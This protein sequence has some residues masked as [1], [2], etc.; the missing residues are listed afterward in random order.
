MF[1]LDGQVRE[2]PPYR[3]VLLLLHVQLP[4]KL[5]QILEKKPMIHLFVVEHIPSHMV[6]IIPLTTLLTIALWIHTNNK[7]GVPQPFIGSSSVNPVS[8]KWKLVRM[9]STDFL[10]FYNTKRW[11]HPQNKWWN[12]DIFW[13]VICFVRTVFFILL[14]IK[15]VRVKDK[16]CIWGHSVKHFHRVR[17]QPEPVYGKLYNI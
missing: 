1:W 9:W 14:W 6:L 8:V 11:S 13:F 4:L 17:E 15:K 10:S 2:I 16:T 5:V 12:K 3:G 7:Q